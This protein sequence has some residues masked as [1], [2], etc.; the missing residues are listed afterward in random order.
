MFKID[1]EANRLVRLD[2]KRFGDL[3]LR[4]RAHL[5]EWIAN[6]PEALG[7]P[8]LILQKEFD[9]F[10]ETKERLDLLALDKDGRLVLIENK[11]D[12]TG[13][14]VVWQAVKY[15]AYVS[16]LTK[17]QIV[18]IF[19]QYLDRQGG[20]NAVELICDFLEED[21]FDEVVLNS[22]NS[23]R[24]VMIAAS[25]RR[26]VTAAA[27]WLLGH[28][29]RTQCFVATPF[30]HGPDIF[31]NISQIIPVREATDF[32]IGVARKDIDERVSQE[33]QKA[34]H[35]RRQRFWTLALE[36]LRSS[37]VKLY[38]NVSPSQDQWLSAGCGIGGCH[39]SLIFSQHEARVEL[40]FARS[41][42]AEN[43]WLFDTLLEKRGE[44]EAAFGGQL[45]W[46][47][48]ADDRKKTLIQFGREF[49]GYDEENWP[50]MI[51]WL[52]ENIGRMERAFS[53]PLSAAGQELRRRA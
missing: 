16:T 47:R 2:E 27:L 3:R 29:I 11:L 40:V 21:E 9:G 49:E 18:D 5:Q 14:D 41:E 15:A 26:E 12:D 6:M 51:D 8:L 31:L 37:G 22:G 32:M 4:E 20:G 38:N 45:N 52:I 36:R 13:R 24:I 10:D 30:S 50:E 35:S 28:G 44:L 1:I 25:F 34:R 19:Q 33:T 43:K 53:G 7:E 48:G 42:T 23:Q 46:N 17:A 39:Y